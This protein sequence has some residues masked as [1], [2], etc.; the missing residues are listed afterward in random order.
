MPFQP[1]NHEQAK[2]K[3]PGRHKRA[4]EEKFIGILR[5]TITPED[6]Q[7]VVMTALAQAKAGRDADR[8][9]LSD[10]LQG[11]VPEK[12]EISGPDG[13]PMQIEIVDYANW[14]IQHRQSVD[15][16]ANGGDGKG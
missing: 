2:R 8:Q 5:S 7:T 14:Q 6:W 3:H 9:W 13:E 10:W 4:I 15:A 11:K 1:G 16:E 12:H